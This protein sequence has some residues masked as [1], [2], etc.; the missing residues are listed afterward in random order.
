MIWREIEIRKK[1]GAQYFRL[2][3]SYNEFVRELTICEIDGV[4]TPTV[5]VYWG[6]VGCLELSPCWALCLD[7]V[8]SG[9]DGDHRSSVD[10]PFVAGF[11]GF[12][13]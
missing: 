13:L 3:I 7:C 8:G 6:A 1:I 11:R 2:Y 4:K 12:D 10:K 9:D 5:R